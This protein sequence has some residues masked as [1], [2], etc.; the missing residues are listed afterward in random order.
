MVFGPHPRDYSYSIPRK[1]RKAAL[2]SALTEKLQAERLL[3]ISEITFPQIRTKDFTQTMANLGITEALILTD[4]DHFNLKMSARNV[5]E[6]KV[7]SVE[8]LNLYDLLRFPTLIITQG[9]IQ[10]LEQVLNQ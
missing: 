4:G 2:R 8:G 6:F 3:V 7:L 5:K 10:K 9:T 1:V